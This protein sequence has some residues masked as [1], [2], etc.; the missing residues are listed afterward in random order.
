MSEYFLPN[1]EF[2]KPRDIYASTPIRRHGRPF[3]ITY[4]SLGAFI[5]AELDYNV[6]GTWQLNDKDREIYLKNV[7]VFLVTEYVSDSTRSERI[8]YVKYNGEFVMCFHQAGR[9][10]GDHQVCWITNEP[11]YDEMIEEICSHHGLFGLSDDDVLVDRYVLKPYEYLDIELYLRKDGNFLMELDKYTQLPEDADAVTNKCITCSHYYEKSGQCGL[12]LIEKKTV[13]RVT[14]AR[15]LETG[16]KPDEHCPV[17]ILANFSRI[18]AP[19]MKNVEVELEPG[20]LIVKGLVNDQPVITIEITAKSGRRR[21]A[22]SQSIGPNFDKA[23]A[24]I[25]CMKNTCALARDP[26]LTYIAEILQ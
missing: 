10:L 25:E 23:E 18:N 26:G 4:A 8:G 12:R 13:G 11:L 24:I 14:N 5:P 9:D 16:G 6:F 2:R 19:R 22:H 21:V 7:E 20:V 17:N 3:N 15:Y 1:P